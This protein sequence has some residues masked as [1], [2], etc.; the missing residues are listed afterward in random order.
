MLRPLI[1]LCCALLLNGCGVTSAGKACSQDSDCDRLQTCNTTYPDGFCAK[2]C[3]TSGSSTECPGETICT[4][5]ATLYLC[6]PRCEQQ[7]DCRDGYEC[8]GV[9]GANVKTCR[10]KA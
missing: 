10:P 2:T 5:H 1:V 9:A 4:Q 3:S 8:N 6:A 7:T